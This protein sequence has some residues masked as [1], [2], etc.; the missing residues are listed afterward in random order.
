MSNTPEEV[1][2]T[3]RL[4]LRLALASWEATARL[5]LITGAVSWCLFVA[6]RCIPLTTLATHSAVHNA[7]SA[8]AGYGPSEHL[9]PSSGVHPMHWWLAD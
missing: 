4:A 5:I 8:T 2:K 3:V 7:L 6:V 9:D 1:G